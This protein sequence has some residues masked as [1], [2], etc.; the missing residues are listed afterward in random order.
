MCRAGLSRTF[1][2]RLI[3][4]QMG[5]LKDQEQQTPPIL[6]LAGKVD[7]GLCP[8]KIRERQEWET[9]TGRVSDER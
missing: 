1:A 8:A 2:E 4:S 6:L 3:Y 5:P 9:E 7:S